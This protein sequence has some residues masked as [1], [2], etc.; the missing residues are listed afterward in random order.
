MDSHDLRELLERY[1]AGAVGTDEVLDRFRHGPVAELG[2]AHVDLNR[3][4]RCGFPEVIFCQGKTAEWIEGVMQRLIAARQDCLATRVNSEQ[5]AYLVPRFPG[6]EHHAVARTLWL[7]AG[8]RSAPLGKVLVVTA[9][10]SD[11]PVAEEA[12]VTAQALGCEVELVADV[13]VAGVHRLLRYRDRFADADA[14]VVVAGMEGALTSVVGGLVDCPVIGVPTSIG[15]GANQGG[16]TTLHAMLS[17]CAS[18][19]AVVNIDSG[20]NGGYVAGLIARRAARARSQ[21]TLA[22]GEPTA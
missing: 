5:A 11:L 8:Q 16:L 18:N 1:R 21:A 19:V 4:V 14:I 13:G 15:Y 12:R 20:F 2:F 22:R 17:S 9:G 3:A 10:T 6:V 7:P